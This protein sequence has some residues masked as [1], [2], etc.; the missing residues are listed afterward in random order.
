MKRLIDQRLQA[1]ADDP[2]R[3]SLLLRGARQVG[4]TYSCRELGKGFDEFV[5]I[6]FE[7]EPR[8]I[9]VFER[10]LDPKRI[11]RDLG[12][13]VGRDI[14]PG[15][16][17]L[18]LDEI[19]EAP[20][21]LKSLR[22]FYELIPKLHVVAAGSL[23]DFVLENIGM[24]VGRVSSLHLYPMSFLEF[25]LAKGDQGL[26]ELLL[27][28]DHR[29]PLINPVHQKLIHIF[30]EYLAT[31]GMPEVVLTWVDT[32]DLKKCGQRQTDLIEAYRQD[33]AKYVKKFQ[34][35]YVELIFNEIPRLL[36]RKFK[37]SQLAGNWRK[38]ELAPALDLLLKASIVHDVRHTSASG[39]P[40]GGGVNPNRFKTIFLDIG[41]AQ[42]VLDLDP[43]DWILKPETCLVNRGAVAEAFVGQELLAYSN[44][45]RKPS[46][47]YWHREAHASNAEVDYLLQQH[48]NIV[49]IEVKSGSRGTLRSLHLFLKEKSSV[50]SR[51]VRFSGHPF[52]VQEYLHSYP[53]YAVANL[54]RD[55]ISL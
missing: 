34:I 31:G 17:L 21:A 41:L 5:E 44:P 16:T 33:F 55:E 18:F 50:S 39:I 12:L 46:L 26:A 8:Y 24:P 54:M 35:K 14:V 22:Y 1:W 23:L 32:E 37:Y 3:K 43:A 27:E 10:D 25:L 42:A 30:G 2:G 36:G 20:N 19:Q 15:K 51:G 6:N 45:A 40:L 28:H 29:S 7:I 9:E 52:S 4:K 48:Q 13:L 11:V 47:Y 53:L 38:R 49:P